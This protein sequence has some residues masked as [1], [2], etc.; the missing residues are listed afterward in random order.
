[1]APDPH[2]WNSGYDAYYIQYEFR[3]G[4]NVYSVPPPWWEHPW[5]K[6]EFPIN[7]IQYPFN[8]IYVWVKVGIIA[9]PPPYNME[10]GLDDISVLIS[11]SAVSPASFGRIKTFFR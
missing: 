10:A 9:E 7:Q 4:D 2:I 11:P 5:Q 3:L 1:L 6:I 8:Y